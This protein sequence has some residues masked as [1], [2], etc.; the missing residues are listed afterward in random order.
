MA[1]V[2]NARGIPERL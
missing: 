1:V 2:L